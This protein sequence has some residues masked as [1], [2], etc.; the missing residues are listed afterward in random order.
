MA[1]DEHGSPLRGQPRTV[2]R[3]H[4]IP[5]GSSPIV[6]S[7]RIRIGGS[8]SSAP[9]MPRRCRIPSENAPARRLAT[10]ESPTSPRQ[11][12][13]SPDGNGVALG[14]PAEAAPRRAAR[15]NARA[16][17]NAPTTVRGRSI[18]RYRL[19]CTS[20]SPAS[21]EAEQQVHRGGLAGSV[22]PDEARDETWANSDRQ[23]VDRDR[24]AVSLGQSVRL[25]HRLHV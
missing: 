17:S 20:A 6:G 4:W 2:S 13:R 24:S 12:V 8:P 1:R 22:R 23:I 25:D 9:A 19:P 21:A 3:I 18:V 5:S 10:F 11:V 7:S 16:S 14:E 15:W